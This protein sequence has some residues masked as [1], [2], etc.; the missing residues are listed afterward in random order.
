M[1]GAPIRLVANLLSLVV[2][3]LRRAVLLL[4]RPPEYVVCE[5]TGRIPERSRR[6]GLFRRRRGLSIAELTELGDDIANS[7]RVKGLILRIRDL[8]VGYARLESLRGCVRSLRERGKRVVAHLAS[9]GN[10]EYALA[11]ACDAIYLDESGPLRLLGVAAEATFLKDALAH[12]GVRAELYALGEYKS[13]GELVTRSDM[14]APNREATTAIVDALYRALCGWVASGRARTPEEAERLVCGGPYP[15]ARALALGL[16]DRVL[17]EDELGEALG[18]PGRPARV[19]QLRAFKPFRKARLRWRPLVRVRRA[20]AVVSVEGV[21][22]GKARGLPLSRIASADAVGRALSQLRRN[23]RIAG[24]VLAV[25]SRGGAADA[26]DHIWRE[27]VRLAREKPVI[28][29]LGDVAA[30]GGYYIVA[31]CRAIVAQSSR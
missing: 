25:D 26:S 11:T 24:V 5:L 30:S 3:L 19:C 23:R 21:I 28:A 29:Y 13:A 17:Y 14:S 31:P 7:P 6:P 10:A 27:V 12:A 18:E 20:I 16:A 1:L 4:R 8:E 22:A 9:P 2:F 15:A